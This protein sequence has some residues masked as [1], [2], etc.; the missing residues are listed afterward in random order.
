MLC[1]PDARHGGDCTASNGEEDP[2]AG[3]KR[4]LHGIPER[5]LLGYAGQSGRDGDRVTEESQG[6]QAQ[7]RKRGAH[8][9]AALYGA[10]GESQAE[11]DQPE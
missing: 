7:C 6:G 11:Y 10:Q 1:R 8:E 3:G 5:V 2:D 4:D 9:E